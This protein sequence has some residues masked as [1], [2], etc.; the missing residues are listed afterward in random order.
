MIKSTE[1][2]YIYQDAAAGIP[3]RVEDLLAR[4]TVE[5]KAAQVL[6]IDRTGD[7]PLVDLANGGKPAAGIEKLRNGVGHISKPDSDMSPRQCAEFN[8]AIQ[9]WL[10]ENTRLKIPV[11]LHTEALHGHMAPGGTVF[12]QA[13]ALGST[14]DP[15][16]IEEVFAAIAKEVRARGMQQV[17][18]PLFDLARDPRMGRVE[19]MYG[20]DPHLVTRMGVA[21]VLGLQGYGERVEGD[22]VAATAKH[23]A[24][25]GEPRGGVWTGPADYG[26]RTLRD[27]VLAPFRA[28]VREARIMSIMPSYNEID[29]VYS[30]GNRWLLQKVL[31]QEWGFLGYTVSDYMGIDD[32]LE[33]TDGTPDSAGRMALEAGVDVELPKPNCYKS[34]A[35]MVKQ[36]LLSE[37]VL[38]ESV[39]RILRIKFLLGLFENPFV[40]PERAE[41]VTCCPEHRALARKT[42]EKAVVLLQNRDA[43]LPLNIGKVRTVAVIGPN[44]AQ[45]HYGGYTSHKPPQSVS[46]LEGIKQKGAGKFEVLY[47]HGCQIVKPSEPGKA[48]DV[49]DNITLT[50]MGVC[51]PGPNEDD[52]VIREA[53]E[54]AK[55]ADVVVLCIGG[56]EHTCCEG[57]E[58][59]H[60]DATDLDLPGNQNKLVNAVVATGKPVVAVLTGGR[61]LAIPHIVEKIPAIIEAWYLG[62]ETGSAVADVLFGD[63]NPGGKLPVS[64]PLS[65]GHVPVYYNR[66][67]K[68]ARELYLFTRN[69][70]LFPFG[71]GLSYTTFAYANPSVTPSRIKPGGKAVVSV[72]VTNTG[73]RAGDEVVQ[74]YIRD[75][76]S[77]VTRPLKEL[78]GFRRITLQP[79]KTQ[80]V[81]FAVTPDMLSFHNEHMEEVVEPGEFILTLGPD[82]TRGEQTT[83]TVE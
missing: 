40:D 62:I 20:E 9:S 31:R 43:L 52:A 27:M 75:V 7:E 1:N 82:S 21:C 57:W 14:W 55:R 11:V 58:A 41:K 65:A 35:D 73:K 60:G 15:G 13:I 66:K 34:I 80:R 8:N 77:S 16:L 63:V 25:I 29:G 50:P 5:E 28:A 37:S 10:R 76:H 54:L 46:I 33:T 22:R 12:P 39:R 4:M 79:G 45:C 59:R 56:N 61:P 64:F 24:A 81:E 3:E 67:K 71:H 74:L 36:G 53:A 51:L 42:A 2:K 38:D 83:L 68:Q 30:H 44:A 72:D 18:G 32:L 78:K 6:A 48:W 17:L 69:V 47:S 23:F 19:E 70:P 26:E 49:V